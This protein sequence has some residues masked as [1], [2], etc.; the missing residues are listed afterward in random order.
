MTR[1]RAYV[2]GKVRD[3]PGASNARDWLGSRGRCR[4]WARSDLIAKRK[5]VAR[6]RARKGYK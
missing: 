6:W 4:A 1:W 3:R 5:R 2:A